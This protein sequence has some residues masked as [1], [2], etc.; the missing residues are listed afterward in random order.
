MD[1]FLND[2]RF[3]ARQ[4]CRQPG[5]TAVAVL[6]LGLGIGAATAIFNVAEVALFRP[7][8]FAHADRLVRIY[9]V[10]EAGT[11]WISL[12]PETY[13]A[14]ERRGRFFDAIVAQRY[15]TFVRPTDAGPERL[16]GIAVTEGWA[17]TLGVRT[18]LG[19]VFTP[20]EEQLGGA[21]GVALLSHRAWQSRFGGSEDVLGRSIVLNNQPHTIV[22]VMQPGL[23]FPYNAEVWVPMRADDPQVGPWA[24]NVQARLAPGVT[25]ET[26][27]TEL[28]RIAR[29]AAASGEAPVL[30]A[31]GMSLTAF[32]LRELLVGDDARTTLALLG[33]VGF[34]LL[35]VCANLANLLVARGLNR[36]RE[37][38]VR[39]SL[40]ARRGRLVR[41][42]LT[43]TL[44]L[45][46]AG[47]A[48]GIGLAYLG[49]GLAQPLVPE[50]ME[51]VQ[52]TVTMNHTVLAFAV[53]LALLTT[54]LFGLLPAVRLSRVPGGGGLLRARSATAD[55]GSRRLGDALV[56][57][58]IALGI[59]LLTGTGLIVQDLQRLASADP[60][61]EPA[62]LLT[63]A[64]AL[65]QD[66]YDDAAARTDLLERATA[67]L[68]ATPE[69]AAVGATSIFPSNQGNALASVE[70]EGR[71]DAPGTR[72]LVNHRLVTPGFH[73]AL[74]VP[75]LA[76]RGI[77]AHDRADAPPV[78]VLSAAAARRFFPA[79]DAIGRRIRSAA[80]DDAEWMTVVG[81]VGDVREYYDV[82]ET[83][84]LPYAQHAGRSA[85]SSATFAVRGAAARAP[86]A[87][88]VRR[89][90]AEVAPDLPA[91]DVTTA[92][93]LHAASLVRQRQ[94]AGLS[95]GFGVFGL[96]LAAMGVYGAVAYSVNR[97]RREFGIRMALGSDPGRIRRAVL[98][99]GLRFLL[100]G[101]ALGVL[102]GIAAARIMAAALETVGGFE[103][104]AFTVALLALAGAALL[105][106]VPP[107]RRAARVD[108]MTVLRE[109]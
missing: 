97:R 65:G 87:T 72:R 80:F 50:R 57:A 59:V 17:E 94:A 98:R 101:G 42:L 32:P 103:P 40:G 88:L 92:A 11:P 41:Q 46:G 71:V 19:R 4:L 96:L 93:D 81:V 31:D 1:D 26:A 15:T 13:L 64:V 45:G 47:S 106:T 34:L 44:L 7:L 21:A 107:A 95:A 60:G 43:E 48:L 24:F 9:R 53:G 70:I 23:Q 33:A 102:G 104:L 77:E 37:F 82:A 90:M 35:I 51:F 28:R 58:E 86:S 78:A 63:F 74:G 91:L 83:W 109:E 8:P 62:G 68:A 84:Y 67:R 30:S 99:Q 2:L 89:V 14:V 10:P 79:G 73:E 49:R 56:V 36:A 108:P 39:A 75:L 55:A 52:A 29:E 16:V 6:T 3:A 61:Y 12:R 66:P 20:E 105:A 54:L 69:I 27:R 76:G 18:H 100:I 38:A 85:A 25:L 5:F 22:G